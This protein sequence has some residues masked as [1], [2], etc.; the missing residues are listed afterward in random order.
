MFTLKESQVYEN[1][2]LTLNYRL[3]VEYKTPNSINFVN[4]MR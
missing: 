1:L 3:P 4:G 2:D